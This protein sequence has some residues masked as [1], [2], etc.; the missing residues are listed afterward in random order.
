M[1]AMAGAL[2]ATQL[3]KSIWLHMTVLLSPSS[4]PPSVHGPPFLSFFPLFTPSVF[5]F[6]PSCTICLYLPVVLQNLST[7]RMNHYLRLFSPYT[8]VSP[9]PLLS[10]SLVASC[11]PDVSHSSSCWHRNQRKERDVEKSHKRRRANPH[12]TRERI[13]IS[14]RRMEE[15]EKAHELIQFYSN[16]LFLRVLW[17]GTSDETFPNLIVFCFFSHIHLVKST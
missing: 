2:T 4:V 8:P 13:K 10:L 6:S 9:V 12:S 15:E 16:I 14:E 5:P 7:V 17:S 3:I 11:A 1:V